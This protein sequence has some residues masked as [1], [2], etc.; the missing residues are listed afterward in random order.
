VRLGWI[1]KETDRESCMCALPPPMIGF[2]Q[3]GTHLHS[4]RC[5]RNKYTC[6]NQ[7]QNRAG[8][9]YAQGKFGDVP[10][11][12]QLMINPRESNWHLKRPHYLPTT[13]VGEFTLHHTSASRSTKHTG[14]SALLF[15]PASPIPLAVWYHRL[16]ATPE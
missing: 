12:Q 7:M 2:R 1:E 4:S 10:S 3:T 14:S 9:K 15:F 16:V 8:N 11:D 6:V 13:E 5:G